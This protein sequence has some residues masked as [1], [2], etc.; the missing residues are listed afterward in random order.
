[1][2][3]KKRTRNKPSNLTAHRRALTDEVLRQAE[4]LKQAWDSLEPTERGE[5]LQRLLSAGCSQRG[6]EKLVGQSARTIARYTQGTNRPVKT[7]V[8]PPKATAS[9]QV[10]S[11]KNIRGSNRTRPNPRTPA[12]S[13]SR[14]DVEQKTGKF[15][16]A[17]ADLVIAFCK[18]EERDP[19]IR[20]LRSDLEQFLV[21]VERYLERY[22]DE[23]RSQIRIPNGS[24]MRLLLQRTKPISEADFFLEGL[25]EWLA[26]A[27][28]ALYP[29]RSIWKAGLSKSRERNQ[30]LMPTPGD[31]LLK[32]YMESAE[33]RLR[34]SESPPRR[35]Y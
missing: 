32:R 19:Q 35:R 23:G 26:T 24:G 2:T 1:M 17:V 30:Q 29:E 14:T 10:M 6:L 22:K 9:K 12:S 16:D 27:L 21:S 11:R 31:S 34:L 25:A 20:I 28:W 5:R 7:R 3:K 13:P 15:S 33:R 4:E 8:K 18:G